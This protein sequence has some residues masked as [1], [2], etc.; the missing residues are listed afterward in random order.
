M[1]ILFIFVN[2]RDRFWVKSGARENDR[3]F[4]GCTFFR[5]PYFLLL[6]A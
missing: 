4:G 1:F 2:D 3:L 5:F 6:L